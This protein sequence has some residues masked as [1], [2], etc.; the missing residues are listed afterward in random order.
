MCTGTDSLYTV[1]DL[2]SPESCVIFHKHT[3]FCLKSISK[4]K[5]TQYIP[6][7]EVQAEE[8]RHHLP[9]SLLIFARTC[10]TH[11]ELSCQV[12]MQSASGTKDLNAVTLQRCIA[13]VEFSRPVTCTILHLQVRSQACF[14]NPWLGA[15]TSYSNS[16]R[17]HA[18]K[19]T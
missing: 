6:R 1:L 9:T 12:R 16:Q 18:R 4:F 19:K 15:C 11:L 17:V 5:C 13:C 3:I 8:C 10:E 7:H 14:D 2:A